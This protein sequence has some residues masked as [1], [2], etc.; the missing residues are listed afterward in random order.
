MR[1]SRP[2]TFLVSLALLL[3]AASSAVLAQGVPEELD[4]PVRDRLRAPP[5]VEPRPLGRDP[6]RGQRLGG[7]RQDGAEVSRGLVARLTAEELDA[8]L[9]HEQ[10]HAR[11]HDP[12]RQAA[13]WL[14]S[15][16]VTSLLPQSPPT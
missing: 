12:L 7:G 10:H 11:R 15:I 5:A 3:L 1:R 4:K 14:L 8:V 2:P 9:L 16:A 13:R 6:Q